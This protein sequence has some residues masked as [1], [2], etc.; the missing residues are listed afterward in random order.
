MQGSS[1]L[2]ARTLAGNW[3]GTIKINDVVGLR[4]A[5]RVTQS[6]D[7]QLS[8]TLYSL[9]QGSA[10]T[11]VS[12]IALL[13]QEL[14]FTI[15][16]LGAEFA[17]KLDVAGTKCEGEW[18][19]HG[20]VG[21]LTLTKLDGHFAGSLRP[22]TPQGPFPYREE[23]V[24]FRNDGAEVRLAGS[25]TIPGAER[26]SAAVLLISGSGA[27]DRDGTVFGHKPFLVM[28]DY[29]T[30]RGV[31]TLR[32]DDRGIDGSTGNLSSSTILDLAGDVL[33]GV[34]FLTAH[35]N[36]DPRKVGLIGHSEG[37]SVGALA[38]TR[39]TDVAFLVL[40]AA[41]GLP[42]EQVLDLQRRLINTRAGN[43]PAL[44]EWEEALVRRLVGV[45]KNQE[46]D[47]KAEAAMGIIIQQEVAAKPRTEPDES[48]DISGILSAQAAAMCTPWFRDFLTYDPRPTLEKVGCPVL[49][50]T[51]SRDMQVPSNPNLSEIKRAL[52]AGGNRNAAIVQLPNLNHLFQTSSGGTPLEYGEIQE[53]IAPTA[54]KL[55]GDWIL[56]GA[57]ERPSN[58]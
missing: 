2:E 7:G 17:G 47:Q 35:K 21:P 52:L 49:A 43:S 34:R 32:L 20:V 29:L 31:A 3:E 23:Q 24:T 38:A 11:E 41:P 33:A 16:R 13:D 57:A 54:L 15:D 12:S 55:I 10:G 30:R 46:D 18:R 48:Y 1:P 6:Q 37:A 28:A 19:Q 14:R 50:V 39:C 44:M 25:L 58:V 51:G 42:G 5:L 9:D 26:S 40:M 27:Q 56:T 36:I 8:A 45:L 4:V 53:T 22:Q